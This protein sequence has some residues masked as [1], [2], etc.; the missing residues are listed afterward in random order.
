M[1]FSW[2]CIAEGLCHFCRRYYAALLA[3]AITAS[4]EVCYRRHVWA[5]EGRILDEHETIFLTIDSDCHR[6]RFMLIICDTQAIFLQVTWHAVDPNLR[7]L[8]HVHHNAHALIF[9]ETFVN[10]APEKKNG[11]SPRK[12]WKMV[13]IA[14]ILFPIIGRRFN[15]IV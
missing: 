11:K 5:D 13:S 10:K 4:C 15:L 6:P 14:V 1:E 9:A 2:L 7:P 8:T 3:T 12:G